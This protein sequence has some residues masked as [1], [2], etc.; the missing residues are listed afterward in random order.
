MP[1]AGKQA[2]EVQAQIKELLEAGFDPTTIHRKLKVGRSSIYRMKRCLQQHGTTY[3]PSE[4]N[5]KNG[6]PKVLTAEQE[7][8]VRE[9][10]RDP[11][12]RNRYLDDLVW[13]IHDRFGIVCSTTTMS[14]LKRKWTRV[15]ESEESGQPLEDGIRAQVME[16]HPTLPLL[17]NG[18][19][20]PSAPMTPA[21]LE[22]LRAQWQ[23]VDLTAARP[24]PS[25]AA[26][27][28]PPEEEADRLLNLPDALREQQELAE[29]MSWLESQP[30]RPL[31]DAQ[32][33]ER[34]R[35]QQPQR[36]AT[37]QSLQSPYYSLYPSHVDHMVEHQLQRDMG[38][39]EVQRG[40]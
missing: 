33:D 21:E 15:I 18:A 14:K 25:P 23:E 7:L 3:M 4:M 36:P 32:V 20:A 17:E 38:L 8:G 26:M 19:V 37:D 34:Q 12:N 24:P 22:A 40:M 35:M 29:Q 13:L 6:R 27:R 39:A 28:P 1:G 30:S 10:L 2:P 16:T 5:K 31:Q 9:W 11:K